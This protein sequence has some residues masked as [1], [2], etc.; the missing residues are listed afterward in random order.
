MPCS[1]TGVCVLSI[2]LFPGS[3][4]TGSNGRARDSAVAEVRQRLAEA[5][6]PATWALTAGDL[7]EAS[8]SPTAS[9]ARSEIAL[10]A[11]RAWAGAEA[12]RERFA[13][14]LARSLAEARRAGCRVTTLVFDESP[15]ELHDDLLVKYGITAVR[16]RTAHPASVSFARST[17]RDA[18]PGTVGCLRSLRWGLWELVDTIDAIELGPRRT[19]KTL[20]RVARDGG[21]IAIVIDGAKLAGGLKTLARLVDRLNCLR[22]DGTLVTHTVCDAV[23]SRMPSR[24]VP[25]ARSILRR[26][27]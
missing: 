2:D 12:N 5:N 8:Q 24:Q 15:R 21:E 25:A 4:A 3:V 16:Q 26:A 17:A 14:A 19:L 18:H 13:D 23:V 7:V 11:D 27:A 9:P 10:I 22:G 1:A 20:D 6:L